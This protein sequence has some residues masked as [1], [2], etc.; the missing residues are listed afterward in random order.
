M[1]AYKV[2]CHEHSNPRAAILSEL[3]NGFSKTNGEQVEQLTAAMKRASGVFIHGKGRMGMILRAFGYR[4]AS[5]CTVHN[6]GD[7]AVPPI[8]ANDLLIV[9]PTGGDPRSSTR[10]LEVARENGACVAAM[11]ANRNGPI[12]RL[13]DLFIEV[14]AKTMLPGDRRRSIQPMC[15]T[16]EQL[17]LLIFDAAILLLEHPHTAFNE[18]VKCIKRDLEQAF[19]GVSERDID[20]LMLKTDAAPRLFFDAPGR[21]LQLLSCYAMRCYHMGKQV[22]VANEV[23][24]PCMT[25]G[26]TLIVSCMD[27][28]DEALLLRMKKAKESGATLLALTG[29]QGVKIF[30]DLCDVVIPISLP[31]VKSLNSLQCSD[32]VYGQCMLLALDYAIAKSMRL[33]HIDENALIKRHTN[34]E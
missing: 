14:D 8:G 2:N 25:S 29:G 21:E 30:R 16:L 33:G 10:F 26:D 19:L 17:G 24:T 3:F 1:R 18:T 9:T 13:A 23:S 28:A 11:T 7:A 22:Y 6:I 12:S 32:A 5:I 27:G 34:L 4:L 31:G 20:D 15:S